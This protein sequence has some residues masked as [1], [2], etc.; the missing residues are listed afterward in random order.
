MSDPAGD[1]LFSTFLLNFLA[2]YLTGERVVNEKKIVSLQ[3]HSLGLKMSNVTGPG[4]QIVIR[5][6]LLL[7]TGNKNSKQIPLVDDMKF[8]WGLQAV[9]DPG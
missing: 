9:N 1:L 6:A 4:V 5:E 7:F 8:I 2:E 3:K